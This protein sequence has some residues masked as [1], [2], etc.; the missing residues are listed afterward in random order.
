[1]SSPVL[2]IPVPDC[3]ESDTDEVSPTYNVRYFE[4]GNLERQDGISEEDEWETLNNKVSL[5]DKK[6]KIYN[7]M[8]EKMMEKMTVIQDIM[9][10]RE[11][12]YKTTLDR[13]LVE[14]FNLK[15]RI[16]RIEREIL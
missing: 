12:E 9:E 3:N 8:M 13:V 2:Y 10:F 7:D 11:R 1:M 14:N 15:Q 4:K 5:L 16:L 6:S